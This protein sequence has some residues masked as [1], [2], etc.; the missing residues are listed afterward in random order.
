MI[1][2]FEYVIVRNLQ[3]IAYIKKSSSK[4]LADY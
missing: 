3:I 1:R 4:E 2:Y